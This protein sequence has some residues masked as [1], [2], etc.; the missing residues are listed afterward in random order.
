MRFHSR[1]SG[2]DVVFMEGGSDATRDV[3]FFQAATNGSGTLSSDTTIS[4]TGPCSIKCTTSFSSDFA[5]L[6][7]NLPDPNIVGQIPIPGPGFRTSFYIYIRGYNLG[8]RIWGI[9]TGD[10]DYI[11]VYD[12]SGVLKLQLFDG[13]FLTGRHSQIGQDGPVLSIN[14]WHRISYTHRVYGRKA[15]DFRVY[16]DGALYISVKNHTGFPVPTGQN[17]PFPSRVTDVS[18]GIYA[19]SSQPTINFDDIYIDN[20]DMLSDPGDI[21]V[22]NK[23]PNSNNVNN[24]P[25]AIGNNPS[26]RW[27][28]VNEQPITTLNGWLENVGTSTVDENYGIEAANIGDVDISGYSGSYPGTV[29][30]AGV[31]TKWSGGL[32]LYDCGVHIAVNNDNN[33]IVASQPWA[34]LATSTGTVNSINQVYLYSNGSALPLNHSGGNQPR[35]PDGNILNETKA[36]IFIPFFNTGSVLTPMRFHSVTDNQPMIFYSRD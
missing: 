18:Y 27:E 25:V 21:R 15:N 2:Y 1:N 19:A 34:Y 3:R 31:S 14:T 33:S 5:Y 8:S 28:N 29:P 23:E 9:G 16:V 12:S 17:T 24:F 36:R 4:K 22:T 13:D 35:S 7:V 30:A 32:N 10:Q 26:N 11:L 6:N 20:S